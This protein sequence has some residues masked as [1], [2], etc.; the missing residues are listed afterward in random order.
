MLRKAF[1]LQEKDEEANKE[2]GIDLYLKYSGEKFKMK[3]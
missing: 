2:E 3:T 1:Q